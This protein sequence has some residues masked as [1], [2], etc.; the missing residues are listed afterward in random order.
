MRKERGA[1]LATLL[2]AG[3]LLFGILTIS[4]GGYI[5]KSAQVPSEKPKQETPNISET[6]VEEFLNN[7]KQVEYI[8]L[9]YLGN[10]KVNKL[11]NSLA[12]MLVKLDK[13]SFSKESIYPSTW[14]SSKNSEPP[15]NA[16]PI[17]YFR[18]YDNDGELLYS[19]GY[20]KVK[21]EEMHIFTGTGEGYY[22]SNEEI[23]NYAKNKVELYEAELYNNPEKNLE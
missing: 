17:H 9:E 13:E 14:D 12:T 23:L 22:I 19:M 5:Y 1:V 15:T 10:E 11:D 6:S 7:M 21:N 8:E 18:F 20:D 2:G 4:L 16:Y 3:L